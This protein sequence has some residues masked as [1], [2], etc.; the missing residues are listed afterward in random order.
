MLAFGRYPLDIY[1][2]FIRFL[3]SWLLPVVTAV[4][5]TAAIADLEPRRAELHVNG[6]VGGSDGAWPADRA[7]PRSAATRMAQGH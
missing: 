1:G 6:D 3:L 5:V 2:Q 4:F 7:R